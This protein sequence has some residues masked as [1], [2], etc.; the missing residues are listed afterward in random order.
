MYISNIINKYVRSK[1][2][3]TSI[4]VEAEHWNLNYKRV[5][6]SKRVLHELNIF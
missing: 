6:L 1:E 4:S 3:E 2:Q 5:S